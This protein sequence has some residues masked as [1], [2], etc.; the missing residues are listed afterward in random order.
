MKRLLIYAFAGVSAALPFC[1]SD[2]FALSAGSNSYICTEKG[3][4]HCWCTGPRDCNDMINSGM[5]S[6]KTIC[7]GNACA[8]PMVAKAGNGHTGVSGA[9]NGGT[10]GA[11]NFRRSPQISSGGLTAGALAN[12]PQLLQMHPATASPALTSLE[13]RR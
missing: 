5:C 9:I 4:A 12:R 13:K 8:C 3:G 6:G 2:A 10:F 7:R 11:R 1:V